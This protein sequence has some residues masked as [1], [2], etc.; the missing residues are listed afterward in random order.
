MNCQHDLESYPFFEN[1]LMVKHENEF[2]ILIFRKPQVLQTKNFND[3]IKILP[4]TK[5]LK[6]IIYLKKKTTLETLLI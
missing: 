5:S 3:D 6:I 1:K 2:S 4:K